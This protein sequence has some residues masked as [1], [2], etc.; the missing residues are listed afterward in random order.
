ITYIDGK[1]G[2]EQLIAKVVKDDALL[3]SLAA[4]QKPADAV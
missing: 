1:A 2:A 3:K 4:A